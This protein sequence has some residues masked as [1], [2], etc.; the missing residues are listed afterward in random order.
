M[1]RPRKPDNELT[2]DQLKIRLQNDK[3]RK[4][5]HKTSKEKKAKQPIKH[6]QT[7]PI[8]QSIKPIK[9]SIKPIQSN[10]IEQSNNQTI[11]LNQSNEQSI[12][13][14]QSNVQSIKRVIVIRDGNIHQFP[15]RTEPKKEEGEEFPLNEQKTEEKKPMDEYAKISLISE[16]KTVPQK[17]LLEW[18]KRHLE[19]VAI[20][21]SAVFLLVVMGLLIS[22]G[23]EALSDGDIT[24]PQTILTAVILELFL[25]GFS[26]LYSFQKT[27]K[28]KL[29]SLL[30]VFGIAGLNLYIMD[31]K[32]SSNHEQKSADLA[33]KEKESKL[34]LPTTT[35]DAQIQTWTDRVTQLKAKDAALVEEKNITKSENLFSKDTK[36]AI[37]ELTKYNDLKSALEIKAV[38][39]AQKIVPA[40]LAKSS[41]V[42][43]KYNMDL[44]VRIAL[45]IGVF[46]L[47]HFVVHRIRAIHET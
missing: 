33:A 25:F 22:F 3:A 24:R 47:T 32:I 42:D 6:N 17:S 10:P 44:A 19:D 16:Q 2:P 26:V 15:Q 14:I 23:I 36:E 35:Y 34:S 7:K 8:K 28:N 5:K 39:H 46:L 29:F 21:C 11:K 45:M 4:L 13:P 31:H 27:K 12:K 41:L 20:M 37:A 38:E 18:N 1:P 30:L 9:Q 43:T 40:S